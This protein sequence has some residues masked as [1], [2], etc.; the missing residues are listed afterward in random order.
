MTRHE[1]G[2]DKQRDGRYFV[3][4]FSKT[5]NGFLIVDGLPE[6]LD[7]HA[8]ELAIGEAALRALHLSCSRVLP[9]RDLRADP[10]DRE[11]LAWLGV[12]S[13]AK[14][15][16]GV[17]EV[18]LRSEFD[19]TPETIQVIPNRNGGRDGFTDIKEHAVTITYENP[20]Q[21]GQAVLD[22]FQDATA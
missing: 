18:S 2:I 22:A 10:P 5:A 8:V 7:A 9:A 4:A 3:Q 17:K 19:E 13:Y 11:F 6:V 15:M 12:A 16:K 20:T 21:L 14:Y 1:V